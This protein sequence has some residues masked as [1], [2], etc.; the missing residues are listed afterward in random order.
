MRPDSLT[1]PVSATGAAIALAVA[2]GVAPGSAQA[3]I[4]RCTSPSGV[5]EYSNTAPSADR[6]RECE[7]LDLPQITTIPAPPVPAP[8]PASANGKSK[9]SVSAATQSRRDDERLQILLEEYRRESRHLSELRA[10]YQDGQPERLGSER[11]YQKYLDRVE[12]LKSDI[13]RSSANL[14]A[15]KSEMD[16]LQN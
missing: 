7:K 6:A 15:L 10:E 4:Y 2:I 1:A 9:A 16:A 5:I 13:A 3:A 14:K 8:P 12:R 11:N